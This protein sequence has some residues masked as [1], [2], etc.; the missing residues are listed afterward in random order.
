MQVVDDH[1]ERTAVAQAAQQVAKRRD[2]SLSL[3]AR[4]GNLLQSPTGPPS[5]FDKLE[6]GEHLAE[7][8]EV[9]REH[10]LDLDR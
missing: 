6:R 10:R 2:A 9:T 4:I 1:D 8:R 3:L 7:V 5:S